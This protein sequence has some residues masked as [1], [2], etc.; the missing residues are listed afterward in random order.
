MVPD[1]RLAASLLRAEP[2]PDPTVPLICNDKAPLAN[3]PTRYDPRQD[4]RP[5]LV[6]EFPTAAHCRA[7]VL[8]SAASRSRFA[9]AA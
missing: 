2:K 1:R 8:S 5:L 7:C 9:C 3:D 4:P 6:V